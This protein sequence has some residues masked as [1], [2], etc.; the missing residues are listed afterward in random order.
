MLNKTPQLFFVLA[1]L[2]SIFS[3]NKKCLAQNIEITFIGNCAFKIKLDSLIL[4]SDFPYESGAYGYMKYD[5]K[6][7]YQDEKGIALFTHTHNDHF[8]YNLLKLTKL[9]KFGPSI[10]KKQIAQLKSYG[11][12]LEAIR[13]KHKWSTNHHS[14]NLKWQKR[15]LY[16]TGDTEGYEGL[17]NQKSFDI[18][19]IT[20]WLLKKLVNDGHKIE[21]NKIIIY[22]HQYNEKDI[23]QREIKS[24]CNCTLIIPKQNAKYVL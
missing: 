19:F 14:F 4:F 5:F 20:P 11:L 23:E 2:F 10:T 6:D 12:E 17:L 7:V 1:F 21:A 18:L 8:D 3:A 9:E 24:Y 15:S 16:F 13:T 22:H